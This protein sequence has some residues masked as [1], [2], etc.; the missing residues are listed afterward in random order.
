[1]VV[2]MVMGELNEAGRGGRVAKNDKSRH[3]DAIRDVREGYTDVTPA[4]TSRIDQSS[5]NYG[6]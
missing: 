5:I 1:M 2:V 4:V 3:G 6:I